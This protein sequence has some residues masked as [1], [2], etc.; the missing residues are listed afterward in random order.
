MVRK[1]LKSIGITWDNEKKVEVPFPRMLPLLETGSVDAVSIVEPFIAIAREDTSKI[2]W[3]CNQYLTTTERTLVATYVTSA[4]RFKASEDEMKK[5]IEAMSEAT[6]FIHEKEGTAREIIGRY[7]KIKPELLTKIGLSEFDKQIQ[8]SDLD[9][10]IYDMKDMGFITSD[11]LLLS[12][13]MI[14]ASK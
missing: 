8:A 7:T 13:K 14:M 2:K 5:F 9:A 3:I 10:V 12:S 4:T 11:K 1:Y 6:D